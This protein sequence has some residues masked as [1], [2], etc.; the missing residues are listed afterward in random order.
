MSVINVLKLFACKFVL[1]FFITNII[2]N[3]DRCGKI[4]FFSPNNKSPN[5]FWTIKGHRLYDLHSL[6]LHN[7]V[8]CAL[9]L[10]CYIRA[11]FVLLLHQLRLMI[12]MRSRLCG[13]EF[14]LIIVFMR[15]VQ[16]MIDNGCLSK[17]LRFCFLCFWI[18]LIMAFENF[19][20]AKNIFYD[21]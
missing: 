9:R 5:Y 7:C 4:W 18:D 1:S 3:N 20:G 10:V 13:N 6:H 11:S 17:R 12:V 19:F 16:R 8:K 21:N 14:N 15:G 2:N